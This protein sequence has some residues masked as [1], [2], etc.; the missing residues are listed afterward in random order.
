MVSTDLL[1]SVAALSEDERIEL[2]TYIE[3]TLDTSEAVPSPEQHGV[4]SGRVAEM[5]ANP[6]LGMSKDEAISALWA[7]RG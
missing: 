3:N 4:V 2:I 6:E 1:A 7:L 5:R